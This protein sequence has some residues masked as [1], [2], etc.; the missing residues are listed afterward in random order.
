MR[1]SVGSPLLTINHGSTFMVTDLDGQVNHIGH[2]GIFFEDT[3]Y[4]SYYAC[5]IDGHPWIRLSST[6]TTYYAA[7]VYLTNPEFTTNNGKVPSGSISLIISRTVEEGIHEELDITN[8]GLEPVSFNLEIAMR[9]DFADIFEVETRQF[10]RRGH[11]TTNWNA[12]K[13]E[14]ATS[15][16]NGDFYRCLIYQIR[17]GASTPYSANGRL[18]FVVQL[19]A[20]ES[21]HEDCN[22]ILVDN[23]RTYS[24]ANISYQQAVDNSVINTE[25]ERLHSQ[26]VNNITELLCTNENLNLLYRQSVEDIGALRL[27]DYDECA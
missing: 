14:L 18:S 12:E 20:G 23:D 25:T 26:W 15:Y 3:R 10:V 4:L 1:I 7:R 6:T 11:I 9:S 13:K 24:T 27:Y 17:W 19:K 21:W 2:Q 5:Y 8:Y 16:K 22:Y